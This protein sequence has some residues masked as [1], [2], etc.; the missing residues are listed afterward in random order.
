MIKQLKSLMA[1]TC[2]MA[3]ITSCEKSYM[4]EIDAI[5]PKLYLTPVQAG[6][7]TLNKERVKF[8]SDSTVINV[9]LGVARSGTQKAISSTVN[10]AVESRDLPS[11]SLSL[12]SSVLKQAQVDIPS[13]AQA[14]IFELQIP[15]GLLKSNP[16]KKFATRLS[17][18]NPTHY[19][20][21]P[22]LSSVIVSID[23]NDFFK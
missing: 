19:E 8:N 14:G 23:V 22:S 20:L 3:A 6:T 10:L 13:E 17:I 21:N 16:G 2:V 12:P 7:I 9:P 11:G 15:V 4:D 5:S 18:S 1:A